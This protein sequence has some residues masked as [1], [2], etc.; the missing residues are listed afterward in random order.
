MV[1]T[2]NG[3]GRNTSSIVNPDE[4]ASAFA[5]YVPYDYIA[6]DSDV[7]MT[8]AV[9][10]ITGSSW[11]QHAITSEVVPVLDFD[12]DTPL[13]TREIANFGNLT[14]QT[15]TGDADADGPGNRAE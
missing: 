8:F 12:N 11:H 7:S 14:A 13:D 10:N 5:G 3:D 15:G 2:I 1:I 9:D 4:S 6:N